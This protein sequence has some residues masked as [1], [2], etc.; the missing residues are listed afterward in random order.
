M[1][2]VNNFTKHRE[3]HYQIAKRFKQT[4]KTAF[5]RTINGFNN[6][7]KFICYVDNVSFMKKAGP[8]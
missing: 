5:F 6:R 1:K 3:I 8:I 4:N 7:E 2:H